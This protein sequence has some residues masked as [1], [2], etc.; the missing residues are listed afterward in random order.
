MKTVIEVTDH[1]FD[2]LRERSGIN[3]KAAV[4]LSERAYERGLKHNETNG[5]LHKYLVSVAY[6]SNKG[7]CLR[8]YGDKVFIF[9]KSS[10]Y[11]E[12]ITDENGNRVIRLVTVIQVP[13]DL[14]K[15]VNNLTSKK[16]GNE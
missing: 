13:S 15:S 3:R 11:N 4:R 1:A 2:R 5:R 10:K 9:N 16:R 8:L 6:N 12:I 7:A 14:I